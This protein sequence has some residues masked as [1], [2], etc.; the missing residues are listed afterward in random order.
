MNKTLTLYIKAECKTDLTAFLHHYIVTTVFLPN[1]YEIADHDF[2][3]LATIA[4]KQKLLHKTVQIV[5]YHL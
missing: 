2:R 3:R 4:Q 1:L 5:H